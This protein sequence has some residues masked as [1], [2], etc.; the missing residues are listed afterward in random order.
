[1]AEIGGKWAASK[2]GS[3][4]SI[5]KTQGPKILDGPHSRVLPVGPGSSAS[6][7]LGLPGRSG[8][9]VVTSGG[10]TSGRDFRLSWTASESLHLA[11]PTGEEVWAVCC[12][13]PGGFLWPLTWLLAELVK[14]LGP[15][16]LD[17][18]QRCD[19]P[20]GLEST[21]AWC[22]LLSAPECS[23]WALELNQCSAA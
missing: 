7:V 10:G 19:S 22:P 1:M 18:T 11:K 15:C 20:L 5:T 14:G 3:G 16:T 21:L 8:R 13:R 4:N 6:P 17:L 23:P 2:K 12:E 9:G